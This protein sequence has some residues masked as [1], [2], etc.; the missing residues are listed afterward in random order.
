MTPERPLALFDKK[1][2]FDIKQVHV[3]R[4]LENI[5]YN[6]VQYKTMQSRS[7]TIHTHAQIDTVM[8]SILLPPLIVCLYVYF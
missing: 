7:P 4:G 3:H 6:L 2:S 5:Q 8:I 1:G